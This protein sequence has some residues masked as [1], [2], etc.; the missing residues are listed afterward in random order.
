MGTSPGGLVRLVHPFPCLLDGGIVVGAAWIAGATPPDAV[1]LGASMVALQAAIGTLNDIVD[2]GADAGRKLAK[3]IPAGAV[4]LGAARV[5]FLAAAGIGVGLAVP[6][7]LSLVI[8]A[9]IV[10]GIGLAY[11]LIAKGSAWSWL[12]FAIGIPI[13]PVYGWLGSGEPLATW[14][15]ALI[16]AA[17]MAGAALAIANARTDT[18]RDQAA[19]RASVATRLGPGASW[20]V[21]AVLWVAVLAIALAGLVRSGT[22]VG[23]LLA[24]AAAWSLVGAG[25]VLGRRA[26]PRRRERAW[27]IQAVGAGL[28]ALVWLVAI[29]R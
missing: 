19:G 5:V 18:E 9:V 7:G 20:L 3:P 24:A 23:W 1:R 14:F 10:L 6:S 16:P 27:E 17:A 28:L 29:T 22:W 15:G 12:P 25:I 8:L 21:H 4:S 26:S 11:D 13:L 2:A